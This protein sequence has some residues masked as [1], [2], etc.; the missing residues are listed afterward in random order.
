MLKGVY[1]VILYLSVMFSFKKELSLGI[2]T[3]AG[4]STGQ[5]CNLGTEKKKINS[6]PLTNQPESLFVHAKIICYK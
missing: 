1:F 3:A 6:E 5:T 4:N 2:Q